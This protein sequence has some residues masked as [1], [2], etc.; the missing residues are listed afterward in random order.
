MSATISGDPNWTI[1]GKIKLGMNPEY[2]M[3]L[4][5]NQD[6]DDAIKFNLG[7]NSTIGPNT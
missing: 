7:N 4:T 5:L 2:D 3:S 1:T 6:P